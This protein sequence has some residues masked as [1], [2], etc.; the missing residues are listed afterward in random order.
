MPSFQQKSFKTSSSALRMNSEKPLKEQFKIFTDLLT[1]L[2][3]IL[4]AGLILYVKSPLL[5]LVI[6]ALLLLVLSRLLFSFLGRALDRNSKQ[7][8]D[9]LILAKGSSGEQ[10]QLER[11]ASALEQVLAELGNI[12]SSLLSVFE[13]IGQGDTSPDDQ[14]QGED[15]S[16]FQTKAGALVAGSK[17][18]AGTAKA[19][20]EKIRQMLNQVREALAEAVTESTQ[21]ADQ[22]QKVTGVSEQIGLLE[23]E[24]NR[25]NQVLETILR[26]NEQ[27]NLLSLNA[28][29]EAARAGEHGK[30]FA[31][32]AERVRKLAHASGEAAEQINSITES[33]RVAV[34]HLHDSI[35]KISGEAG[36]LEQ[37]WKTNKLL[38][39]VQINCDGVEEAADQMAKLT[40]RQ[41]K[42]IAQLTEE[43][44]S[45]TE[46]SLGLQASMGEKTDNFEVLCR[47]LS[48][49]LKTNKALL[50][51]VRLFKKQF[52]KY[53]EKTSKKIEQLLILS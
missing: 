53:K 18:L 15:W 32:V 49:V 9:L 31:V 52:Q 11:T 42:E 44:S 41:T 34:T 33:L 26:I 8:Q 51:D 1:L 39:D 10:Q 38:K 37:T 14:M 16:K 2:I 12:L 5:P 19:T 40:G 17:E 3:I 43:L 50:A 36:I 27:T 24:L 6:F 46:F 21:V 20:E 48:L 30:T 13:K 28:A 29:I 7:L 45:L 4:S 25:I 23:N 35:L 22:L 47:Q